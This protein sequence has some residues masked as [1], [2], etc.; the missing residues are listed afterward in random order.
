MI[1]GQHTTSQLFD[2]IL[3]FSE[4]DYMPEDGD[5]LRICV[6]STDLDNSIVNFNG[7]KFRITDKGGARSESMKW[8]LLLS[9]V[10]AVVFVADISLRLKF[11]HFEHESEEARSNRTNRI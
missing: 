3:R 6:K 4:P 11:E 7:F 8:K 9:G 5:I 10:H 1:P 2:N